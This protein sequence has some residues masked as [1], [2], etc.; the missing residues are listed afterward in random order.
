MISSRLL[1][2]NTAFGVRRLWAAVLDDVRRYFA[3]SN[4]RMVCALAGLEGRDLGEVV[5]R[6]ITAAQHNVV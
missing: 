2:H 4:G 6:R 5:I 3:S 1:D